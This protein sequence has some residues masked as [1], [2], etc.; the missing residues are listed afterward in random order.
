MGINMHKLW[1]A[2]LVF[3][4]ATTQSA[5][6]MEFSFNKLDNDIRR[7][8]VHVEKSDIAKRH[9][10]DKTN[11]YGSNFAIAFC[12]IIWEAYDVAR[13]AIKLTPDKKQQNKLVNFLLPVSVWRESISFTKLLLGMGAG[14]HGF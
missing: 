4:C 5:F 6:G 7:A 1:I 12:A 11:P 10:H 2:L 13:R 3:F 9:L 8:L 14:S